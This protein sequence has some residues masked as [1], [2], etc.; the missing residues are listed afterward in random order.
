MRVVAGEY[1]GRPLKSLAG[2]TTRPTTDKVKGSIFN[3]LGQYFE[4]G[5]VL[6]LFAGSGGLSIEAVSRG[7]DQA[8]LIEKDRSAQAVIQENI[9]M[10]KESGKFELMKTT[11]EQAI[12]RLSGQFDL[13]FLDP[14]YAKEQIVANLE[15]L[16][17]R[18]LL[19]DQA[20]AVCETDKSVELPESIGQLQQIKQKTY[21]ISKITIYE[22]Q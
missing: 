2:K 10:T 20:L 18:D 9:T 12:P 17:A 15:T 1:G 3:M 8:V 7:C 19:A 13:L 22:R 11:A 4:G 21:G 5:R 14:P 6:D 16:Q